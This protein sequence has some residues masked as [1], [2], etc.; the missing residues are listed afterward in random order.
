MV[1]PQNTATVSY[2]HL[3]VYKRQVNYP[4]FIRKLKEI[5]YDGDITIERELSG[6]EQKKDI[7][8]AKQ[9]LEELIAAC[10][11]YTSRCV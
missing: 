5:G 6:E 2:T 11:L 9:M 10:L 1:T 7:L 3:D 4:A 8:M